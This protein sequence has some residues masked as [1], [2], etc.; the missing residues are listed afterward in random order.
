MKTVKRLVSVLVT[1]CLLLT[2]LGVF[3]SASEP[4]KTYTIKATDYDYFTGKESTPAVAGTANMSPSSGFTSISFNNVSLPRGRYEAS[5]NVA[6][7]NFAYI[8]LSVD[9]TSGISTKI[10]ATTNGNL[11]DVT[12][13][14][15]DV[16]QDCDPH[17]VIFEI[18]KRQSWKCCLNTITFTYVEALPEDANAL[19]LEAEASNA[20]ATPVNLL[21]GD[22]DAYA[23]PLA[24]NEAFEFASVTVPKA[25]IYTLSGK[26]SIP[27]NSS[28][29]KVYINDAHVSTKTFTNPYGEL[30]LQTFSFLQ[31]YGQFYLS[32]GTHKI[33]IMTASTGSSTKGVYYDYFVLEG[34][35]AIT[36]GYTNT[37]TATEYSSYT[38]TVSTSATAGTANMN[39]AGGFGSLTFDNVS[40]P[41][42]RYEVSIN[43]AADNFAYIALSVDSKSGI[44]KKILATTN[45]ALEDVSLG[46]IDVYEDGSDHSVMFE[47]LKRQSWKCN[48]NTITFTL[49]EELPEKA[50]LIHLE[51]ED[52]DTTTSTASATNLLKGDTNAVA[53]PLATNTYLEYVS[54]DIDEAGIYTLS[55]KLSAGNGDSIANVYV[56]DEFAFATILASPY[57]EYHL[58]NFSYILEYGQIYLPAGT[59]KIKVMT[60]ATGT[61]S[62]VYYDYFNLTGYGEI[63]EDYTLTIPGKGF[64]K[65]TDAAG[66]RNDSYEAFGSYMIFRPGYA[67]IYSVDVP[68]GKYAVT[69]SGESLAD[70]PLVFTVD[71]KEPVSGTFTA[72]AT[73]AWT[74]K[75]TT[76][77]INA[78]INFPETGKYSM[79]VENMKTNIMIDKYILTRIDDADSE[80][81]FI[82]IQST[83]YN[84]TQG[85]GFNEATPEYDLAWCNALNRNDGVEIEGLSV[86][87]MGDYTDTT[88]TKNYVLRISDSEWYTYTFTAPRSGYY[89]MGIRFGTQTDF[90]TQSFKVS[91]NGDREVTATAVCETP[92][93]AGNNLYYDA[94]ICKVYLKEGTNTV[95]IA[96]DVIGANLI[97]YF[98]FKISTD[99]AIYADGETALKSLQ[100]G[101][102]NAVL[103]SDLEAG[104]SVIA[105]AA[106]YNN[107]GA[108]ETVI[109]Y[110]TQVAEDGTVTM[111]LT[112]NLNGV[113]NYR[114]KFFVWSD[115]NTLVPCTEVQSY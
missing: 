45:S 86:G 46:Y 9:G 10:N 3:V 42:G 83:D 38:G 52:C 96:A 35:D 106:I 26:V 100:N 97:D 34:V 31:E 60:T 105:L 101:E 51:A 33:K 22:T 5:I 59:H 48:L 1:L 70:I 61:A 87:L 88:A 108:L 12:L 7:D 69:V 81:E 114:M 6:A 49:V 71:G 109:D 36:V 20:T 63:P 85:E 21:A 50:T 27:D 75:P 15:I 89:T 62:T 37:L 13:G 57:G 41:R 94:D 110:P 95:K 79:C 32:A 77:S 93:A 47:I 115:F 23:V 82:K 65:S 53:M 111:P 18:F 102:L 92:I 103:K 39:P 73:D 19:C 55:G 54:V 99:F 74:L 68:A 98:T 17:T 11:E 43:V 24:T 113:A 40:L 67:Y 29:V 25:G 56:N 104:K 30:H 112:L 28:S 4:G 72:T 90:T 14:Y 64:A 66:T 58:Q 44:S 91:A 107:N 16:Y 80:D 8:M 78:V 2:T 84:P 76:Q